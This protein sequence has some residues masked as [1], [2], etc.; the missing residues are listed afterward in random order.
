MPF[1]G[2]SSQRIFDHWASQSG[3]SD[4]KGPK[5]EGKAESLTRFG[6]VLN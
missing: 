5:T 1:C 3:Y 6:N 4:E 2:V